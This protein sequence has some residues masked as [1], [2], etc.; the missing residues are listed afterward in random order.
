M[1][2]SPKNHDVILIRI[3]CKLCRQEFLICRSCFS[4][5]VYCS[6]H[7]RMIARIKSHRVAQSKYRTSDEGRKA[8]KE[9]EQQRRIKINEK[10]VADHTT[11]SNSSNAI[12]SLFFSSETATCRFCGVSGRV[13]ESFPRRGYR[14]TSSYVSRS[15]KIKHSSGLPPNR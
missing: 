7:C 14:P 3:E 13:V 12:L 15:R 9:A 4:G 8:N 2:K 6:D 1:C 11:I 10:T 5:H